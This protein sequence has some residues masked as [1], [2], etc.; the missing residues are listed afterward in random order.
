M[1]VQ[2]ML[3][4]VRGNPDEGIT[5]VRIDRQRAII[6][7]IGDGSW[8]NVGNRTQ[9]GYVMYVTTEDA[10][11]ESGGIYS[12]VDWRSH[13]LRRACHCTLYAEAMA[14][15]AAATVAAGRR[16]DTPRPPVARST[17]RRGW[18]RRATGTTRA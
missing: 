16:P 11:T 1:Q 8:A 2:S 14:S 12:M 10:L 3:K 13:R 18:G 17:A 4:E 7:T 5:L 9:A 15:R 6:V